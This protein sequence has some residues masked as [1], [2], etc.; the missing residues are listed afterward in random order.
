[1]SENR[2]LQPINDST[3]SVSHIFAS[4]P[5]VFQVINEVIALTSASSQSV[6]SFIIVYVSD[7][8]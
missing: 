2:T 5:I 7:D 6:I 4:A 1:M 8:P 3:P